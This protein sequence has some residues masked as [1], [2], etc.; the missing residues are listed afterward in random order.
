[1]APEQSSPWGDSR[2]ESTDAP[3]AAASSVPVSDAEQPCE[4]SSRVHRLVAPPERHLALALREAWTCAARSRS[5]LQVA[6]S[7]EGMGLGM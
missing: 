5:R 7:I 2:S 3:S 1:M 4:A 6:V